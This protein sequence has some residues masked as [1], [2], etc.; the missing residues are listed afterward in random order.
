[1]EVENG[2]VP[3]EDKSAVIPGEFIGPS[4]EFLAGPGC[5]SKGNNIFSLLVG[6]VSLCSKK[7]T[8][9][10][11]P[12]VSVTGS[13]PIKSRTP[14]VG[15]VVICKV[16][17]VSDR[18][19]KVQI[20]SINGCLLQEPFHGIIRREDIRAMEKDSVE[21]FQSFRPRDIVRGRVIAHGEGQMYLVSTAEN[22]L[23][24]VWAQ[25]ECGQAMQPVSWCEMQCS[26]GDREKRKVAK[27]VGATLV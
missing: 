21:V 11:K 20:R 19:A 22:E 15:C 5:Y 10:E 13:N 7:E 4:S 25:C 26:K 1:M 9:S 3:V 12:T 24:I 18:H 23:G 2:L 16:T 6:K 8:K 17:S 14:T 27:V